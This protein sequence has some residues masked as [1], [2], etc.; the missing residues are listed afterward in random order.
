MMNWTTVQDLKQQ[1][2]RLWLRGDLL[3]ALVAGPPWEPRRLALK[4][5]D[6][7]Q[8]SEHFED[9]RKWV[10]Q[11]SAVDGIRIQWRDINHRVIG[12][13]RLPAAVWLDSAEDAI[14]LIGKQIELQALRGMLELTLQRQP[15]LVGWLGVR[16]L[17][18]VEL[19]PHWPALLEVV[20]WMKQHPY[21][22]IY[23]RQVDIP[24]IHT[25]FIEG[26]RAVLSELFDRVLPEQAIATQYK[27]ASQFC[28]RYGFLE[29]TAVL[30]FRVLDSG[31]A[32]LPGADLPD[33]TLDAASFSR[34]HIAVTRV[35][36]TE[37]ETNFLAFPPVPEAIVIFG[38]GYGWETLGRAEWLSRCT[39]YYWGDI[40]THG[41]AILDQLRRK[42][43]HVESLLMDRQTLE[44]HKELWGQES[45]QVAH[46]LPFLTP[47]ERGLFDELRDNRLGSGVRLEQE[48]VGFGWLERA[49]KSISQSPSSRLC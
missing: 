38:K 33:I 22:G 25:K 12:L 2:L 47:E 3:R 32:L 13:Q 39:M 46:D 29:K 19:A 16:P 4:T 30:R 11:L 45:R 49:L 20:A 8:L 41:F 35:F 15:S 43:G 37:N 28:A 27:G 10:A 48:H 26:H 42:F 7:T 31:L 23:L 17:Q 9:V 24:D 1:M 21:P 14:K 6:T 5:P 34:L 44:A 36:V 18:A 40:D